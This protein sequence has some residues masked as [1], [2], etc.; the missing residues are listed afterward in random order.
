MFRAMIP[1]ILV[2][3]LTLI[4][5]G[6]PAM[7]FTIRFGPVSVTENP[8]SMHE[9]AGADLPTPRMLNVT[10]GADGLT[11]GPTSPP[12]DEMITVPAATIHSKA[13][14]RD[15]DVP[16]TPLARMITRLARMITS[17]RG[18]AGDWGPVRTGAAAQ[19]G[20]SL[21]GMDAVEQVLSQV[22]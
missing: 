6:H 20:P 14:S 7:A 11:F 22:P 10:I 15:A 21:A 4:N 18:Q 2:L 17:S 12:R 5:I 16:S 1:T 19:P 3:I 8:T 9:A 13:Q